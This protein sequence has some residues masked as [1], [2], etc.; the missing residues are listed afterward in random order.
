M[1]IGI[2][3]LVLFLIL[4]GKAILETIWGLGLISI[5]LFW[6]IVGRF[7]DVLIF[8]ERRRKTTMVCVLA[9]LAATAITYAQTNDAPVTQDAATA[10]NVMPVKH[11]LTSADGRTIEVVITAKTATGIKAKKADGK[12]F[13]L[14][15]DKLSDTDRAFVA[16]LMEAPVKQLTALLYINDLHQEEK[17]KPSISRKLEAAGFKVTYAGW[18]KKVA[19]EK[20]VE[21]SENIIFM[22]KLKE[23]DLNSFD[24]IWVNA[25]KRSWTYLVGPAPDK[26]AQADRLLKLLAAGKVVVWESSYKTPK[27]Q[28]IQNSGGDYKGNKGYTSDA[29]YISVE[30]NAIFYNWTVQKWDSKDGSTPTVSTHPETLDQVIV[31]AK[32]LITAAEAR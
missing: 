26:T 9:G 25:F 12:D 5:G 6:H 31:E 23:D 15:L 16:G 13:E 17:G 24:L 19:D 10:G 28:F 18:D 20:G 30:E 27:K 29:A 21:R 32:K 3:L 14:T 1:I 7:L 11:T 2:L 22:E 4:V 8:L